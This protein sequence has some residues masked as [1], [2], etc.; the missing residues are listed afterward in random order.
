MSIAC[1][2]KPSGVPRASIY[3]FI[4]NILPGVHSNPPTS[5]AA[6]LYLSSLLDACGGLVDRKGLGQDELF[7][8]GVPRG[9]SLSETTRRKF[10]LIRQ[11][12][13]ISAARLSHLSHLQA[14]RHSRTFT[15]NARR[16][17]V[18]ATS[19]TAEP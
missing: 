15:D 4:L 11:S 1:R 10:V 19:L 7:S 9:L 5:S 18:D 16:A 14:N 3:T 6:K 13:A 8:F 17:H 12:T 2:G